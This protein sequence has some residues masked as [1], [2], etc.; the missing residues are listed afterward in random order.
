MKIIKPDTFTP[1]YI[2]EK[3]RH[4][5]KKLW[6]L[7]VRQ[8]DLDDVDK[9]VALSHGNRDTVQSPQDWDIIEELL[10][11]FVTRWPREWEEF[12]K[13]IPQI[14]GTRRTGGY[15]KSKEMMY[16][17]S[18]PPRFERLIK[19]VFPL[20]QF[21]KDFIYKLVNKFKVFKVGGENK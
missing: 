10:K 4:P 21:N 7:Q 3:Q 18:L 11:F 13:V 19:A 14:K 20:Q 8:K 16:L 17:A 1:F 5:D 6:W 9:L 15:S 12:A 2:L